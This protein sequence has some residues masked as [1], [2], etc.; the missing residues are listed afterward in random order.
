MGVAKPLVGLLAVALLVGRVDAQGMAAAADKEKE[1]R[2]K[3]QKTAGDTAKTYDDAGLAN[4]PGTLANDPSIA[5]AVTSAPS[6]RGGTLRSGASSGSSS[7]GSASTPSGSGEAF[8]RGR[9]QQLR[10]AVASAEAQLKTAEAAAQRAGIVVPGPNAAPCQA[11]AE[12]LRG[13]GSIALRERSKRT[14]TCESEALRQD[15]ARGAQG[16]VEAAR[17]SLDKARADLAALDDQARRA[18]AQPGWIR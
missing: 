7:S 5:P 2:A 8:W 12:R 14:V 15:T 11:G 10:A 4:A 17:R 1:R 9:A 16:Q 3:Q 13:E 6:G 18:G